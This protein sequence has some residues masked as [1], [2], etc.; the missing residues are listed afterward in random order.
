M[1][2]I[3]ALKFQLFVAISLFYFHSSAYATDIRLICRGEVSGSIVSHGG[4]SQFESYRQVRTIEIFKNKY[5]DTQAS[6]IS[7]AE[8][9]FSSSQIL[10]LSPNMKIPIWSLRIDRYSGRIQQSDIEIREF[11]ATVYTVFRNF[12]GICEV[13]SKP[14]F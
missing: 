2:K 6:T 8:I 13:S 3:N 11:G 9:L 1:N 4:A 10:D 12:E 5:R 7:D 14:K